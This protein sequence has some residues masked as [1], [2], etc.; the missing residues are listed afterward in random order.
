MYV[1]SGATIPRALAEP[2][3][4]EAHLP[5]CLV[6][7][8]GCQLR[9]QTALLAKTPVRGSGLLKTWCLGFKAESSQRQKGGRKRDCAFHEE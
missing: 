3:S 7:D 1:F 4:S 8:A 2:G 5:T 9:P 6:I